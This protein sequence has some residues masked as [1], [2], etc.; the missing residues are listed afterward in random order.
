VAADGTTSGPNASQSCKTLRASMGTGAF[1]GA[2]GTNANKS[3]AFGK[4]VS[5]MHKSQS[6][7]VKNSNTKCKTE[8]ADAN[9]AATHGGK[10]F[11]QFYGTNKNGKN[12]YGKCVSTRAK[13]DKAKAD[14]EDAARQDDRVNAAKQCKAAKKSDPGKFGKDY[15]TRRNAFGKC[16]SS[17]AKKLAA[18]R[19][20]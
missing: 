6:A 8:Q 2:Y 11:E 20:A 15:G 19:K 13:Q 10:T 3:N 16:V 9:F 1:E 5:K 17:T 18:E 14:D 12:A 4:C 7:D